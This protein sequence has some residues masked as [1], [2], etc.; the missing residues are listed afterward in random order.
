[1]NNI[2]NRTFQFAQAR[3]ALPASRQVSANLRVSARSQFA[4]GGENQLL[5]R[6]MIIFR[7]H[8]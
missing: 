7:Q 1:M 3:P 6:K 2:G 4:I 8:S 5:I